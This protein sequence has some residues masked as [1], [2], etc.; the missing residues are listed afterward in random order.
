MQCC[1]NIIII[2]HDYNF[3]VICVES[4]MRKSINVQCMYIDTD[5]HLIHIQL[6]AHMIHGA[7]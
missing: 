6:S 2:R 7:F 1:D 5:K 4:I 3:M